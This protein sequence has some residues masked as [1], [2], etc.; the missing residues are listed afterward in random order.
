MRKLLIGLLVVLVVGAGAI[1]GGLFWIQRTAE[2]EVDV[3]LDSWRASVGPASRGAVKY[4]LWTRTIEVSDL[5]LQSKVAPADKVTMARVVAAGVGRAGT[6]SRIDI[7]SWESTSALPGLAATV[8]SQKAPRITIEGYV[9]PSGPPRY[10]EV[11]SGVDMVRLWL[12]QFAAVT[13]KS[14]SVPSLSMTMTPT[15]AGRA[16]APAPTEYTYTNIELRDVRNGRVAEITSDGAVLQGGLAGHPFGKM[17]GEVGKMAIADFDVAPVLAFLDPT[18]AKD[19]GY[20]RAYR[21]VSVGPYV[22]RFENGAGVRIDGLTAEDVGFN[23]SKLSLSDL[24]FIGEVSAPGVPPSPA[25]AQMILDK[26]ASLY[27][28]MHLGKAE[29]Q[30]MS[31]NMLPDSFRIAS[32]TLDRL[33]N[34]RLG[35]F[36]ME[37]LDGMTPQREPI[38]IGRFALKG[39]DIAGLFRAMMQLSTPGRPPSPDQLTG[40]LKLLEGIDLEQ[41]AVPDPRTGRTVQIDSF[42]ASWGEFIGVIPSKARIVAKVSGPI[43]LTDPEPLKTLAENG[44]FTMATNLDIG[45]A[46]SEGTG[47]LTLAPA[48]I[49]IGKLFAVSATATLGNVPRDIFSTDP[50]R[51]LMATSAVEVGPIE[52]SLRDQGGLDLAAAQLAKSQGQPPQGARAM[53]SAM[54]AQNAQAASQ[55]S[56]ELQ[57]VLEAIGRFVASNGE[58]LTIRLTPRG[59]VPLMLVLGAGQNPDAAAGLLSSFA[60]EAKVGR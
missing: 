56:P 3:A 22:I 7:T 29:M 49:D 21:K 40:M 1:F 55:A 20:Q 38:K 60:L 26:V 25:Q 32:I 48:T 43:S 45:L 4:D 42:A 27:E 17:T 39:F 8:V 34:G 10:V 57:A 36:V 13:A 15:A 58:T 50:N 51:V 52:L 31:F 44:I 5:A 37:G 19:A 14:I 59:R 11:K 9:G 2:R 54:V 12:E 41:I 28:G 47:A 30:G 24:L 6:A 53:L 33:E 35:A 18:K 23:P 46:W 16:G